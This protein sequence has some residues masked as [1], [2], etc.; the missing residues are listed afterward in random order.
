MSEDS[1]LP[2]LRICVDFD[3][4]IC[5]WDFPRCGPP[6]EG[7]ISALRMLKRRGWEILIHTSRVNFDWPERERYCRIGEMLQWLNDHEV[8]FDAVWGLREIMQREACWPSFTD[9]DAAVGKPVAHVYLDDR[10]LPIEP[11]VG[12]QVWP[13]YGDG[14]I[15]S[16]CIGLAE[17][18]DR[19]I[20]GA[21]DERIEGQIQGTGE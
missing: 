11:R 20:H 16:A 6:R 19:Q 18:A 3:G 2:K 21:L 1:M 8:P 15:L 13:P 17:I 9:D 5:E 14:E 12:S 7:V 4:T 10:A